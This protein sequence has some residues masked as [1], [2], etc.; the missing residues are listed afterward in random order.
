MDAAS[1]YICKCQANCQA[2]L[3]QGSIPVGVE[4][5]RN[6]YCMS[7]I[8]NTPA[9]QQAML[10]HMGLSSIED[11]LTN[12]P[13]N[14]R[15]HRQL[16]LPPALSEPDLKRKMSQMASRNKDL[17]ST[18]SFLGAGTY[19]HVIPSVVPHLLR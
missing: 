12:V 9:E 7:Y 14:V 3:N 15:F 4:R 18:I 13:E 19:D 11:L 5:Q 2:L 1:F 6:R 17:D 16:A 10:A 8:P